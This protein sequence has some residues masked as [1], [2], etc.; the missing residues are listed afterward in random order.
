MSQKIVDNILHNT[1][2]G[3]PVLFFCRFFRFTDSADT[4]ADEG[5]PAEN[6]VQQETPKEC[7]QRSQKILT[8]C[9]HGALIYDSGANRQREVV[10]QVQA[11]GFAGHPL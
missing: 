11:P 3:E 2:M 8:D 7:G 5:D 9:R 4:P 10:K 1:G 6:L